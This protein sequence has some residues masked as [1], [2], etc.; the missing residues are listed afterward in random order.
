[1]SCARECKNRCS[2][3]LV[4]S[5][6]VYRKKGREVERCGLALAYSELWSGI[7]T[8]CQCGGE[9]PASQQV[10]GALST[11]FDTSVAGVG[12]GGRERS[13]EVER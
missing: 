6:A 12:G 11:I 7:M 1:M 9:I 3:V 8:T 13:K 2:F 10:C 4:D 5:L